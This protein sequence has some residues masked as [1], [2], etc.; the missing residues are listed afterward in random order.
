MVNCDICCGTGRS[1]VVR[2]ECDVRVP[3]D[4]EE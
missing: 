2:M 3:Y 1:K 4:W